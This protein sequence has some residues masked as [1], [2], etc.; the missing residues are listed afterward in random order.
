MRGAGFSRISERLAGWPV[1]VATGLVLILTVFGG[2]FLVEKAFFRESPLQELRYLYLIRGLSASFLVMAL[3]GLFFETRHRKTE[4]E[5]RKFFHAVE[6]SGSSVIIADRAAHIEYVN[7]RFLRLTGYSEDELIGQNPRLFQSGKTSRPTYESLW[8]TI[9]AGREWHGE[10][11]N[12]K[13][14]GELF[15]EE[16][17]IAPILDGRRMITH[18]VGV[19]NDLTERKKLDSL[20]DEFSGK[21]AHELRTPLTVIQWSAANLRDEIDGPLAPTYREE[22]ERILGQVD[23]L[24]RL[25]GDLLDLSRLES[26]NVQPS[27]RAVDL[28]GVIN[29]VTQG[30]QKSA[31]Q[32]QLEI[33]VQSSGILP[34]LPLDRDMLIQILTN[35]TD[36]ALRFAQSRVTITAGRCTGGVQVTVADDGPGIGTEDQARLFSKFEQITRSTGP[37][38]YKG[39]GLGL[40]ICQELLRRFG[41]KIWVD[42]TLGQGAQFHFLLPLPPDR[43]HSEQDMTKIMSKGPLRS[44]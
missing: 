4:L 18:Y 37:D 12:K 21:V 36:N 26:G 31:R 29:D 20:K 19:L 7:P 39:T 24:Q 10:F 41:G 15:W 22:A 8:Q 2:I 25:I 34:L 30:F 3:A 16:A 27:L 6:Q 43:P 44:L 13:K 33:A 28:M 35:L 40:S 14:N 1:F 5:L 38:G 23:R 11:L 42:S 9:T 32:R 17:S